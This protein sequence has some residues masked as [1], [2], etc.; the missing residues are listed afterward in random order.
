M[1]RNDT[2]TYLTRIIRKPK[3][4]LKT[5][6]IKDKDNNNKKTYYERVEIERELIQCDRRRFLNGKDSLVYRDKITK[7]L[8]KDEI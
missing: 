7:V 4:S 6:G 1:Q 5:L 2:F 8:S 3:N